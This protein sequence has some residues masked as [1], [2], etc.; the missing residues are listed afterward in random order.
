MAFTAQL[1]RTETL[2][3]EK[4]AREH[5]AMI[6]ERY[7]RLQDAEAEQFANVTEDIV[8]RASVLAPETPAFVNAPVMEQTP[9]ITEFTRPQMETPAFTGTVN[10]FHAA[11]AVAPMTTVA[12][13][14]P[15]MQVNVYAPTKAAVENEVHYRFSATAKKI[16]M[17]VAATVTAMVCIIGINSGI[18]RRNDARL[19]SLKQ[20]E[21]RLEEQ[22]EEL[23]KRI[24]EVKDLSDET[25]AEIAK[26]KNWVKMD[27]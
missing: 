20:Q 27:G 13:A 24:A 19:R 3:A 17:A 26:E 10:S 18:M 16:C 7:R 11:E 14:A 8:V 6:K 9:V 15:A 23:Q 25:L 22:N 4:I 2:Q 5:N 1:E 12:P 21:Q